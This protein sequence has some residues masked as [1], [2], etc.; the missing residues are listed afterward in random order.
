MLEI[1]FMIIVIICLVM[2]A[3]SFLIVALYITKQKVEQ[4]P[5][6]DTESPYAKGRYYSNDAKLGDED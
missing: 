2:M 6:F 5:D 1:F 3:M 4:K